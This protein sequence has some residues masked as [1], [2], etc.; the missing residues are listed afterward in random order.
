M[1]ICNGTAMRDAYKAPGG[2]NNF[3][4]RFIVSAGFHR[5]ARAARTNSH[6]EGIVIYGHSKS[7]VAAFV[8][9]AVMAAGFAAPAL[10]DVEAMN[11]GGGNA[12]PTRTPIKHV[13]IIFGENV[14]F[15]HYFA[16]YP[17][18]KNTELPLFKAASDSPAVNGLSAGLLTHN[19]NLFN[20]KR[21]GREDAY[22]CSFNHDYTAEQK[23][24]DGGLLDMFVQATSR[25]SEGCATDGSTVLNYFDGNTVTAL[26]SYAQH[27]SMNDNSFD[28]NFGPST[29][30]ALNLVSGQTGNAHLATSFVCGL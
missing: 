5:T 17:H 9:S 24:A 13:V 22:T 1:V 28:T 10:A 19:P 11:R 6:G 12:A 14:S 29:V 15:D 3:P 30:G 27:Y 23:A 18:A 7:I 4:C 26:W 20:P 16:T 21:L 8:A 25:V 2:A